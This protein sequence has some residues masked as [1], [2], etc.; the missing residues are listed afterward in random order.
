[1][2][3]LA[4]GAERYELVLILDRVHGRVILRRAGAVRAADDPYQVGGRPKFLDARRKFAAPGGADNRKLARAGSGGARP[5]ITKNSRPCVQHR[6]QMM[7]P[8]LVRELQYPGLLGQIEPSR[9]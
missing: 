2:V 5:R 1:G 6:H 7:A 3:W 4:I 9:G 8:V